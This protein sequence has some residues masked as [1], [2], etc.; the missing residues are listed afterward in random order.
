MGTLAVMSVGCNKSHWLQ[1]GT[2]LLRRW[3]SWGGGRKGKWDSFTYPIGDSFLCTE[4]VSWEE[5]KE[6]TGQLY[7]QPAGTV[8]MTTTVKQKARGCPVLCP[9]CPAFSPADWGQLW[10]VVCSRLSGGCLL[11]PKKIPLRI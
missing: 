3:G 8:A 2:E 11:E 1:W 9:S 10:S 6:N 4:A 5:R 7:K